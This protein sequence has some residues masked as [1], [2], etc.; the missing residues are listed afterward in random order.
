MI[1]LFRLTSLLI[2][3]FFLSTQAE[4]SDIERLRTENQLLE[5]ELKLTTKPNIYFVFNLKDKKVY[6][7][8][9][10]TTLRELQVNK[11]EY[12]GDNIPLKPLFLSKKSTFF[13]PKREKIKPGNNKENERFEIE[14]LELEDMPSSYM[15]CMDESIFIAVRSR[16]ESFIARLCNIGYSFKWHFSRPLLALWYSLK[17]KP[18][19]AIEVVLDKKS[20]QALYWS[21]SEGTRCIIYPP[22]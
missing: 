14:A 15:L 16:P 9:H 18:F 4:S 11:V 20:T 2:L 8:A 10:G 12:W 13:K 22:A 3:I 1:M 17:R 6:I 7:K 19:I 5:S 21:F